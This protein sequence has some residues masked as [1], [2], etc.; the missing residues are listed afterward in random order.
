MKQRAVPENGDRNTRAPH[1]A[2]A[3]ETPSSAEETERYTETSREPV[4]G[5]D[6]V[7]QYLHEIGRV[8]LL[9][10]EEEVSLA[11]LIEEGGAAS[12]GLLE[13]G[14][15]E[16]AR[17][18]LRRTA[19][20]GELARQR[21]TEANL[22]LVVSIAKKY[23]YRGLAFLDL[24]QEG[25]QGLIRAVEKFEYRRGFKF[26]T[27][28]TWWIRQAINRAISDQSRTIRL[29]V[30]MGEQ[31]N[32]LNRVNRELAQELLREPTAEE[33]AATMGPDWTP[34]K[35]AEVR[36]LS[37][38]P[39]PLESPV[40]EENDAFYGDFIADDAP[41]ALDLVSSVL[42]GEGLERALAKLTER[43]ASV[44]RL[45]KGFFGGRERTLEEVG[46]QFGVTRERIRQIENKALRKLKYHESR[47]PLL[48]DFLE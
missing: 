37:R 5:A 27:Y 14:L 4:G 46:A 18:G 2:E 1:E 15:S 45:R 33:V 23:T 47:N 25:N 9:K 44:L 3:G 12:Q 30:H 26:S 21:L 10:L 39:I 41:S 28:A 48:R 38:L 6:S 34:D 24:I 16:R 43:E 29:P 36:D 35:I 7:R 42:L 8:P 13:E 17:R 32:K 20:E 19:E 11:R 31:L 22:R 40:G